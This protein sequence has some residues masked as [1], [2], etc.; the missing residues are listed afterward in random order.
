MHHECVHEIWY[1]YAYIEPIIQLYYA[2]SGVMHAGGHKR[3]EGECMAKPPDL[4][5][6]IERG[7]C[8]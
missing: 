3:L 8:A 6:R 1:L 4:H 2:T 7:Q 5:A